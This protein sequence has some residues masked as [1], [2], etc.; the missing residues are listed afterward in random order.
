MKGYK[1]LTGLVFLNPHSRNS[2]PVISMLSFKEKDLGV[3]QAENEPAMC[4]CSKG[5]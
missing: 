3:P 5:S 2:V 1:Y 4:P